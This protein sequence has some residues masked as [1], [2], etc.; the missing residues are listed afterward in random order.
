MIL[1]GES[2]STRRK[3]CPSITLSTTN[4]KQ[5]GLE[6]K[7]EAVVTGQRVTPECRPSYGMGQQRGKKYHYKRSAR[8]VVLNSDI[9]CLRV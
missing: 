1:T 5:T 3:S 6:L 4:P 8:L 7:G 9:A 2:R